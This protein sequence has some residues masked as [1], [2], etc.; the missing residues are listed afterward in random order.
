[1][2]TLYMHH[3]IYH[4]QKCSPILSMEMVS[5]TSLSSHMATSNTHWWTTKYFYSANSTCS[6]TWRNFCQA[7]TF[8]LCGILTCT[9]NMIGTQVLQSSKSDSSSLNRLTFLMYI[10]MSTTSTNMLPLYTH[11]CIAPTCV[12]VYYAVSHVNTHV[13]NV[14]DYLINVAQDWFRHCHLGAVW[15]MLGYPVACE[16][17]AAVRA[18]AWLVG[19][20]GE[21]QWQVLPLTA[22]TTLIVTLYCYQITISTVGLCVC[23][24]TMVLHVP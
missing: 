16:V 19:A 1:M 11:T 7:K 13:H 21:V 8:R 15:L 22:M 6:W 17:D 4:S 3:Y 20:R 2:C 18:L 12:H 14:Q 5:S 10:I 23:M 24:C 9:C